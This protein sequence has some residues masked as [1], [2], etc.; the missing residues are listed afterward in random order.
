[1]AADSP[2]LE[3]YIQGGESSIVNGTDGEKIITVNELVPYFH[4]ANGKKDL[5]IPV[6][7]LTNITYPINAAIVISGDDNENTFMVEVSNLT[8]SERNKVLKVQVKPLE[9]YEGSVLNHFTS[10]KKELS[11]G[12]INGI[13]LY[14]EIIEPALVNNNELAQTIADL[15]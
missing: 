2:G 12:S 11:V 8:L 14:L 5:L 1:M 7:R 15:K 3:A 4:I 13:G 6:E 9:F 10:E